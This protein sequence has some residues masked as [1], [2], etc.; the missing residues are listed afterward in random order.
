MQSHEEK[1]ST[2]KLNQED[3]KS[4]NILIPAKKK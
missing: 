3:L 2:T 4:I 1:S